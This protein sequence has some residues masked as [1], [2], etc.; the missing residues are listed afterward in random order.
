[1]VVVCACRI[2]EDIWPSNQSMRR[3]RRI[4][5]QS[6]RIERWKCVCVQEQYVLESAEQNAKN[7]EL[8]MLQVFHSHLLRTFVDVRHDNTSSVEAREY[9]LADRSI[10]VL[11]TVE[12]DF[13]W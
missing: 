7:L 11:P 13:D 5:K 4:H 12:E 3:V 9:G 1:M 6:C 10:V 2:G 8:E